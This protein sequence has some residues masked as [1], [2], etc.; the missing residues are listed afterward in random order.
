MRLLAGYGL[1]GSA[2]VGL[3]EG[4]E[5]WAE[6]GTG[7]GNDVGGGNG[8]IAG[9]DMYGIGLKQVLGRFRT[10][11]FAVTGSVRKL[12][13]SVDNY[14]GNADADVYTAGA[15]VSVCVDDDCIGLLTATLGVAKYTMLDTAPTFGGSLLVGGSL[16][17]GVAELLTLAGQHIGVLAFRIAGSSL[18]FDAGLVFPLDG[19]N[20]NG[21]PMLGLGGRL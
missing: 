8:A 17:R 14:S 10:W 20:S 4:T 6:I 13:T 11:Q 21:V 19:D 3:G 2:N 12:K 9:T 18:A 15:L 16:V 7:F 1:V 5:L